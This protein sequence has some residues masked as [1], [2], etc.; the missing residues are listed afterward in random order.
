MTSA[1]RQ[2]LKEIDDQLLR[3]GL[4][5]QNILRERAEI[6]PESIRKFIDGFAK[7]LRPVGITKKK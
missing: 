3:F 6:D 1:Q 5:L 4:M 2:R 7:T